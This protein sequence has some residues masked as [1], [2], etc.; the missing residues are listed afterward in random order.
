MLMCKGYCQ[1]KQ[2]CQIFLQSYVLT[3]I[4]PESDEVLPAA[5]QTVR[6]CQLFNILQELETILSRAAFV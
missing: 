4:V 1:G 2:D 6:C 5:T 3:K